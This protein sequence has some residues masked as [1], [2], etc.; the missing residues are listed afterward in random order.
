TTAE[1]LL[2]E[3]RKMLLT[4]M[5]KAPLAIGH[6]I[7]LTNYAA[8][9]NTDGLE[10]EVEAF[11]KLFDTADVKEGATAFLEKRKANFTGK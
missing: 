3:T 10:K 1:S 5:S 6:V 11:G 2:A 7:E 8:Y 4:I 9:G